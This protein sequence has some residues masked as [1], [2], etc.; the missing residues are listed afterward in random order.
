MEE[1]FKNILRENLEI[2]KESL[3]ILKGIRRSGRI[4]AFLKIIYWLVIIGA[5]AGTY[6]LIQPYIQNALNVI[7]QIQQVFPNNQKT[8][9]AAA[10]ENKNTQGI[11]PDIL[12]NLPADLLKQIQNALKIQ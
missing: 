2:S 8:S 11:S 10:G 9:A 5:L 7:Q 12:K 1:D 4:A 6:Y 3:K